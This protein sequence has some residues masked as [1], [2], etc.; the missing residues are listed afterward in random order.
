[1]LISACP[2]SDAHEASP[3][4]WR[5]PFSRR[6]PNLLIGAAA[7]VGLAGASGTSTPRTLL[8]VPDAGAGNR[9][10]AEA[11]RG[12]A[13][14]LPAGDQ[15][16]AA[17]PT[18]AVD[19][20]L[21]RV[22]PFR[23][24]GS[25]ADL[26]NATDCLASA[27]YYEAG[28][29]PEGQA[30]VAQ[31]VINRLRHPAFP[32]SVCGVVLQGSQR[33]TGCQF[34]FTCDGSLARRPGRG[35]W[36]RAK[37]TATTALAG[38]VDARVGAA[39]HYH[40]DYVLP[41]WAPGLRMVAIVGRHIFYRWPGAS[42]SNS[43]ILR[44]PELEHELMLASLN[45][46]VNGAGGSRAPPAT[47]QIAN[48][49]SLPVDAS[50]TPAPQPMP[51]LPGATMMI[52]A[53]PGIPTGRWAVNARNACDGRPDCLVLAYADA[54][55]L[56]RNRASEPANRNTPLFLFVRDAGSGVELA[57]WD[58]A[59]IQRPSAT[60]CLPSARLAQVR[61]LRNRG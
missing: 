20:K 4:G 50:S 24:A 26:T 47:D 7:A 1:M 25:A 55:E 9:G 43:S 52:V 48:L 15:A 12:S 42:G 13:S 56:Q 59:R 8:E 31:V 11:N 10:V 17:N 36:A 18:R 27:V 41:Y 28:D 61:L 30:A 33:K 22:T 6:L 46:A 19:G 14:I 5:R 16:R 3:A 45:A 40:A 21:E 60:Q 29:D 57:L 51:S 32:K 44:S 35:A 54:D 53:D 37:A 49:G 23:F 2:A 38:H 39:T 34:T 58:C